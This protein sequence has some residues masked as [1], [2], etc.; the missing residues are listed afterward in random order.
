MDKLTFGF[1]HKDSSGPTDSVRG[2]WAG[3][4]TQAKMVAGTVILLCVVVAVMVWTGGPS[5]D[6]NSLPCVAAY[7]MDNAVY[8]VI[9]FTA[10]SFAAGVLSKYA[11]ALMP[12]PAGGTPAPAPAPAPAPE[13]EM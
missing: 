12:S 13:K 11:T 7:A 1:R 5:M 2:A 3:L 8:L 4:S 6:M 10:I 9:A